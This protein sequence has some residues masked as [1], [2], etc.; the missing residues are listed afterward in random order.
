MDCLIPARSGS[1]RIKDKNLSEVG[2][3]PFLA[4][5]ILAA[6]QSGLF[7]QVFC[8]SDSKGYLEIAESYGASPILRSSKLSDDLTSTAEVVRDF[9]ESRPHVEDTDLL[10]CL[11]ATAL[12]SPEILIE[13]LGQRNDLDFDEL[14]VCAAEFPHPPSRA[15]LYFGKSYRLSNP[16]SAGESQPESQAYFDLGKF[17]LATYGRWRTN[18]EAL[19]GN[20]KL[21]T[22]PL[23][24][25]FDVNQPKDLDIAKKLFTINALSSFARTDT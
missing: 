20:L 21:Y 15:I 4:W 10:V 18:M 17:Y 25:H 3:K 22:P 6:Q 8:S 9:A 13:G 14:L 19:E 16:K 23:W 1:K 5:A 2:G 7:R 12:V 11:Y 24:C